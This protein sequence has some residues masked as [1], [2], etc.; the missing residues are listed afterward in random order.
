VGIGMKGG[1]KK[2]PNETPGLES[3][4]DG[5]CLQKSKDNGVM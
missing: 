4:G 3:F 5:G 1:M 2:G